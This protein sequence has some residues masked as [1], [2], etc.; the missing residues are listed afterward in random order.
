MARFYS[1]ENFPLPVVDMLR[2]LGHDVLT[3]QDSGH[4]SRRVPDL[5]VLQFAIGENRAVLTLNRR[6]FIALHGQLPDH[7]RVVVCT[8]DPDFARQARGIDELVRQ[9]GDLRGHLLRISRPRE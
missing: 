7:S 3:V 8:L 9:V 4:A 1:N 2:R 6:H 5:E